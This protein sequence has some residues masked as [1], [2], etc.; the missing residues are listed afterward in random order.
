MG[1]NIIYLDGTN[2]EDETIYLL[3]ILTMVLL[4]LAVYLIFYNTQRKIASNQNA[5]FLGIGKRITGGIIASI[6][7]ISTL[8]GMSFIVSP[9]GDDMS[10]IRLYIETSIA[11]LV[12]LVFINFVVFIVLKP[13]P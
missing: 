13:R 9:Y 1:S 12:I 7:S 3:S 4:S 8:F 10:L 5:D 11:F 2:P 6:I